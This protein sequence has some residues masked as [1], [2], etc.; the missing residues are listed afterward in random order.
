MD[1]LIFGKW[2][3]SCWE[4]K[5]PFRFYHWSEISE[6]VQPSSFCFCQAPF[7]LSLIS[8]KLTIEPKITVN[9]RIVVVGASDTG[10]SFLEVLCFWWVCLKKQTPPHHFPS[11]WAVNCINWPF[12]LCNSSNKLCHSFSSSVTVQCSTDYFILKNWCSS[13]NKLYEENC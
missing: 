5:I 8:R 10:L 12:W 3:Q 13:L 6:S 4:W 11:R 9:A 2:H 7:A 1:Y